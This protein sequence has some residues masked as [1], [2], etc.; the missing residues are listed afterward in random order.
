LDHV[1]IFNDRHLRRILPSYLEYHHRTRTHLP[2]AKD[3]PKPRPIV[4]RKIGKVV[5]I[6]QVGRLH[7]RYER[8]A[9]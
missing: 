1:V 2:L 5:A 8:R 3:C 9:A 6:S 4:P 7:H